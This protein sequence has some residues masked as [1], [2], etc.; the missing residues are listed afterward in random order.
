MEALV[1]LASHIDPGDLRQFIEKLA[2]YKLGDDAPLSEAE[3]AALIREA[4]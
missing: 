1:A 3:V 4:E 2:L